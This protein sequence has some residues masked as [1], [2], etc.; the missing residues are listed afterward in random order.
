MDRGYRR[1][2]AM[3]SIR[4]MRPR[5]RFRCLAEGLGELSLETCEVY[6]SLRED[7]RPIYDARFVE[8]HA[9]VRRERDRMEDGG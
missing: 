8:S 1:E 5:R 4:E 7:Q 9:A 3:M 2:T 6:V